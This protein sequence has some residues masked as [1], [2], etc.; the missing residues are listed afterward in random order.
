M[1]QRGGGFDLR[2]VWFRVTQGARRLFYSFDSPPRRSL[3]ARKRR[4]ACLD[5]LSEE[6]REELGRINLKLGVGVRPRRWMPGERERMTEQ[7][8]A[9]ALLVKEQMS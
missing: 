4:I 1:A 8:R 7:A 3:Y 5:E 9:M 2:R 6:Q